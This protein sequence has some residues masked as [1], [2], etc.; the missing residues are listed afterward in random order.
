MDEFVC[1]KNVKKVSSPEQLDAYICVS[2]PG[3]WIVL[4]A[5]VIL[6]IGVCI[7]GIFGHLDTR[8]PATAICSDGVL[9]C[10]LAES[11]GAG[12]DQES[13][14]ICVN[15]NEYR[16]HRVTL[17]QSDTGVIYLLTADTPEL[18]E[19]IYTVSVIKNRVKPLSFV[20]N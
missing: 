8:L 19:G 3:V 9:Q 17:Q 2:A 16:I 7:W 20:F 4:S 10:Y 15:G 1:P 13:A 18:A 6:L 5:V 14:R 11:D 12:L